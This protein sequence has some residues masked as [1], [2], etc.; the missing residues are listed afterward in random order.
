MHFRNT[1]KPVLVLMIA[2]LAV[3]QLGLAQTRRH[4]VSIGYG[5]VTLDQMSDIIEDVLLVTL[6]FGSFSKSDMNFS[7]APF[8]TYHYSKNSHFGFGFAL[9]GYQTKGDLRNEIT[10][11]TTGTFKETNYVAAVEIDYHWIVRK[12]F[13][14][15]SGLGAGVRLR[16]GTYDSEGEATETTNKA[17]PTFHINAI[18]F[19]VGGKVGLFGE[20]GAGYKGTGQRRAERPVL[21]LRGA[22]RSPSPLS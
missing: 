15:Y 22:G 2:I 1:L 8:L 18:G 3:S 13:Q 12:H 19:R 11:T 10:E 17:L 6:T 21:T 4:D 7:G 20:L 16:K 14:L 9:G 5:A